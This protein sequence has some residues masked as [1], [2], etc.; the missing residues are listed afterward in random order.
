MPA[1]GGKL[2]MRYK[3]TLDVVVLFGRGQFLERASCESGRL[4]TLL[5]AGEESDY[6]LW[7]A[8]H[9]FHLNIPTFLF[10]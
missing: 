1:T 5:A 7:E 10:R 3:V 9:S 4:S 8:Q 6:R 2:G